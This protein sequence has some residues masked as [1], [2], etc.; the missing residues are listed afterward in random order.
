M[1]PIL[2]TFAAVAL[3]L[4][5]LQAS[6]ATQEIADMAAAS[7]SFNTL[8]AAAQASGL[9]E[10]Y[11]EPGPITIF[12]PTDEAFAKLPAG[13][14][15]GLLKPENKEKLVA[16]LTNHIIPGRVMIADLKPM[17]VKTLN[18]REAAITVDAGKV[19]IDKSTVTQSDIV[20]SNGVIHVID[21]VLIP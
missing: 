16:M 6:D 12:A 17:S 14:V 5:S 21:T 13:T 3:L 2:F 9:T 15:E 4:P 10:S 11:K 20:F 8:L 7:G 18:G 1:K 19:H